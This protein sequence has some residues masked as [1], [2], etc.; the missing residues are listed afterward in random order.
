[1]TT[2]PSPDGSAE[3]NDFAVTDAEG[4]YTIGAPFQVA[5]FVQGPG[6][7]VR[8]NVQAGRD[9][10][11]FIIER[12][13]G[14]ADM[15]VQCR[16]RPEKTVWRAGEAPTFVAEVRNQGKRKLFITPLQEASKLQLDGEW[17]VSMA[18]LDMR[19]WPFGPG[20]HY[21]AIPIVLNEAWYN[22]KERKTLKL[23][24][25]KHI[26]R[27]A[28]LVHTKAEI[29]VKAPRAISNPVEIEIV[30]EEGDDGTAW[31]KPVDGLKA[32]LRINDPRPRPYR[33]GETLSFLFKVR[34]VS[35]QTITLRYTKP[36]FMGYAPNVLSADGKRMPVLLLASVI[37]R[38]VRM[39]TQSLDPGETFVLGEPRL[40]IRSASVADGKAPP[41]H[42]ILV[43]KPGKYE[44]SY[45]YHFVPIS[46]KK[47]WFGDLTTGSLEI[48]VIP[49]E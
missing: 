18:D 15:G 43:A 14:K 49:A 41:V 38:S 24:L 37:D 44:V 26:V 22:N 13:W 5:S 17:H 35:K 10:V 33:V 21:D 8:R 9:D 7:D 19:L 1:M 20:R 27:V 47:L 46:V 2:W 39:T 45:T 36:A 48:E 23:S 40:T 34:N 12:P 30:P 11:D 4:R 25:G 28:F 31:G 42:P 6:H 29:V 32:G 3:F 16:L